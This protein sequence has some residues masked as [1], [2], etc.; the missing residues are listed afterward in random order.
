MLER[1]RGA[2][3]FA[4]LT[5][6]LALVFAMGGG[7]YA[8]TSISG[9]GG[10]IHGCYQK[11]TGNLRVIATSKKCRKS[12]QAIA[13]NQT[14]VQGIQGIQ[15]ISGIPGQQGPKGD[16]GATGLQ[17]A[18]GDTGAT[19]PQGPGAV[20]FTTTLPQGTNTD[21]ALAPTLTNGIVAIGRCVNPGGVVVA[22]ELSNPAGSF[23]VSG[24]GTHGTTVETLDNGTLGG[25][26]ESDANNANVDVLARDSSFTGSKFARVDVHGTFGSPCTY[27]GM[28]I[29]SG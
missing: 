15:G 4:N 19:G 18:K 5:A 26:L 21:T 24:I 16:T 8:L 11:R 22:L 28:I 9:S 14:G 29:P 20:T 12:E 13:W 1:L 3:T 7:A 17:G 6:L 2:L 23:Q 25:V 10:V 27:W